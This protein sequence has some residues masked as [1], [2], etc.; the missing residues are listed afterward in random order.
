MQNATEKT[1]VFLTEFLIYIHDHSTFGRF[2]FL[3][4]F[5]MLTESFKY[6]LF[7]LIYFKI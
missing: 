3:N 5:F 4:K 6:L 1:K 2:D 7:I